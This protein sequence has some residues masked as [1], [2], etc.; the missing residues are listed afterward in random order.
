LTTWLLLTTLVSLELDSVAAT[1]I[2]V[3]V[4]ELLVELVV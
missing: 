2:A 1:V 3:L 4:V